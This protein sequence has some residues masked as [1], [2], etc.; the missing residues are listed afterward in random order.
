MQPDQDR[1]R[2]GDGSFPPEDDTLQRQPTDEGIDDPDTER[3]GRPSDPAESPDNE[4][5]YAEE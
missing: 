3:T 1:A 5:Y 4:D 2:S